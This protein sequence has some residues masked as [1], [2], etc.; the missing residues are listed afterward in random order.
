[1]CSMQLAET[2]LKHGDYGLVAE[3]RGDGKYAMRRS[4]ALSC[5]GTYLHFGSEGDVLFS[6]VTR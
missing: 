3:K 5:R 6:D 2:Y 4:A 1:M